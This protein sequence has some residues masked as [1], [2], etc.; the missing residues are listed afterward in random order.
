MDDHNI[1]LVVH[2]FSSE[3][4]AEQQRVFFNTPVQLGKFQRIPCYSKL[5]TTDILMKICALEED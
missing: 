5:S 2:G 4:D 1:D 3:A